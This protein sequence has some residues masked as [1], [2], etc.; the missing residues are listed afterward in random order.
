MTSSFLALFPRPAAS[1]RRAILRVRDRPARLSA[2]GVRIPNHNPHYLNKEA[3]WKQ[4]EQGRM[5]PSSAAHS[6]PVGLRPVGGV[7]TFINY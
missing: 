5:P 6:T 4:A 7:S 2:P 3:D 1:P